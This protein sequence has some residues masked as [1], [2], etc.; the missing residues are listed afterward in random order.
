MKTKTLIKIT[1]GISIG[2]L[3]L[4]ATQDAYCTARGCMHSLLAFTIGIFGI[5]IGGNE[6]LT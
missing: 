3:L 6:T 5:F 4:M 2:L 1:L